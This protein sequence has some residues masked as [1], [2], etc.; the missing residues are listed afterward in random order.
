MSAGAAAR[1]LRVIVA[2]DAGMLREAVV[3]LLTGAGIAVVAAVGDL[4]G[5]LDAAAEHNPDVVI[6][7]MRMPPHFSD[8][9][10]QAAVALQTSLPRTGVLV[11]SQHVEPT[12]AERLLEYPGGRGYLLKDRVTDL[13]TFLSALA[14]VA[15]GGVVVDPEVVDALLRRRRSHDAMASLT[16]REREVLGL[17]AEGRSN[18]ALGAELALRP[19]TV[20]R[21][22]GQIFAKLGLEATGDE[23]RRV[24]AVLT[25]L[26]GT[27]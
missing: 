21:H 22:I 15:D 20:D 7:D 13:E 4:P 19:K 6:T 9:G 25:W 11:F 8:E 5:L 17:M 14:Q 3:R 12:Y 27:N 16:P 23:H 24:R 10:L 18:S 1:G 2:E 26:G